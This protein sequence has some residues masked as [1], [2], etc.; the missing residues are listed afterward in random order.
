MVA[1][2]SSTVC[3]S[4]KHNFY[5]YGFFWLEA[6]LLWRHTYNIQRAL[7][8]ACCGEPMSVHCRFLF[9]CSACHQDILIP[10]FLRLLSLLPQ[11][12][13]AMPAEWR[14]RRRERSSASRPK[15]GRWPRASGSAHCAWVQLGCDTCLH[16]WWRQ[17]CASLR[18]QSHM[19][20]QCLSLFWPWSWKH[21]RN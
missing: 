19:A 21:E 5:G 6:A 9:C 4:E 16:F 18:Q 20:I 8:Y 11:R 10:P 14:K 7:V 3:D 12:D 1:I 2:S 17:P 13:G 15:V